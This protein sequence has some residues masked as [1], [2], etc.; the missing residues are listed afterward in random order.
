MLLMAPPSRGARTK[1]GLSR[2]K[3]LPPRKR[4]SPPFIP[5]PAFSS[6]ALLPRVRH[7]A[8]LQQQLQPAATKKEVTM[9]ANTKRVYALAEFTVELRPRGW[10]FWRTYGDKTDVRGPYSSVASV[11]LMIA[12]QLSREIAKRD[13]PYQLPE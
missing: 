5:R 1:C 2:H 9:L 7:V 12:R 13:A 3:R 10:Y 6:C 8:G 4:G 11:T